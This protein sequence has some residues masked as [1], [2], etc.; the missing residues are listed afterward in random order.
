MNWEEALPYLVVGGIVLAVI[1]ATRPTPPLVVGGASQASPEDERTRIE[2]AV[3]LA[4]VAVQRDVVRY[5]YET[6]RE[7]ARYQLQAAQKQYEAEKFLRE[8]ELEEERRRAE[9]EADAAKHAAD[10]QF[11]GTFWGGLFGVIGSGLALLA[12]LSE[13]VLYDRAFYRPDRGS[14]GQLLAL[15]RG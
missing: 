2:A 13:P 14:G 8:R 1:M 12:G 4:E 3:R 15:R 5:Q 11:W 10:S 6:E 9:L 7:I